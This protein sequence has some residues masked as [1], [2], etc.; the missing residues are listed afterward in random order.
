MEDKITKITAEEIKDSRGNPTIKVTAWAGNISGS[1]AV[2]SGAST[3][4]HEVHE[5]RDTDGRGVKK[6]IENVNNI[7]HHTLVGQNVLNQKEIDDILIRLDGTPNKDNLGGNA[8]IGTSI[9]CVKLA[10]TISGVPV[11]EYLRKIYEIKPSRSVPRL[12]MNM[13]EGGKHA[14]NQLS[15]QEYLLVPET[16]DVKEAV[17]CGVKVQNTL[18]KILKEEFGFSAIPRGHEGGL[19][20]EINLVRLPL[21]YLQKAIRENNLEGK[22]KIAL[23]VAASSF[24]IPVRPGGND[25]YQVDEK[26]ISRDELMALYGSLIKEFDLISIEGPFEQEDFDSFAKLGENNPKLLVVGD[27]LTVTNRI[28]LEK[29]ISQKSINALIIK[30]NQIGTLTETLEVMRL[31][32]EAEIK[33]IISHRG[34]ET[35]DDFIANLAFAYG[36]FGLK[37]GSPTKSERMVK[38]Q[39][40]INL[41]KHN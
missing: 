26:N 5:L 13:F 1:F 39:K 33:L 23:D 17:Q 2:P 11:F 10:A 4:V 34:E 12:F 28:L 41:S 14:G 37:A 36:C 22:V 16:S 29:A 19:A 15:F 6:A 20:P 32:R 35:Y 3:G 21:V 18:E 30:P 24:F 38:Y 31:G 40:L 27:D 7:I 9:A 8:M 25:S